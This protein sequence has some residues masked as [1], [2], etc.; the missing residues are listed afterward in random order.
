MCKVLTK[1]PY[2][3]FFNNFYTQILCS[4]YTPGFIIHSPQS[5][6]LS[7]VWVCA[8]GWC[9]RVWVS[10]ECESSV[11]SEWGGTAPHALPLSVWPLGD[12]APP[13]RVLHAPHSLEPAHVLLHCL[14]LSINYKAQE[15][16]TTTYYTVITTV[17]LNIRDIIL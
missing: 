15:A 3:I 11:L 13:P 17:H 12:A 1:Y 7:S 6:Y 5:W 16:I 10:P 8:P 9:V 14:H 2:F 4:F